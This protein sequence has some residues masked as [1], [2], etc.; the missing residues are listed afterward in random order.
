M[1]N[2][3]ILLGW[4]LF[5]AT[6]VGLA[7]IPVRTPLIKLLGENRFRG[8]F[9]LIAILSF[10]FLIYTYAVA[11]SPEIELYGGGTLNVVFSSI[12]Q[13]LMILAFVLLFGSQS[14]KNPMGMVPTHPEPYGFTRI[15][16]HPM[17]MA[18]SLFGLAHLLTSKTTADFIFFGGFLV[19]GIVVSMHQDRKKINLSETGFDSF[20]AH[21]SILPFGAILTGKQAFS[22]GEFKWIWILAA[23]VVAVIARFFHPAI[24]SKF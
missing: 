14:Q 18:F 17:N 24:L 7:M 6:H 10:G 21:T 5:L 4:G 16:R 8:L 13:L 22:K 3:L 11:G 12:N 2:F 20:V 23:V 15:T 9:S 1:D 19:F